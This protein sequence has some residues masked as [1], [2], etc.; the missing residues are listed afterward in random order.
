MSEPQKLHPVT[1][2]SQIFKAIKDNL[3]TIGIALFLAFK[4]GIDFSNWGELIVPGVLLLFTVISIIT[5]VVDALKTTYWI[6]DDKLIMKSGVFTTTVKELYISRIQSIEVTKNVVNQIIGGVV[7]DVKT[8]GEGVKLDSIAESSAQELTHYLETR[9][10]LLLNEDSSEDD[11]IENNAE[12]FNEVY[13]LKAK[14]ILLMSVT[15]GAM[16]TVLA[17]TAGLYTQLDE[18]FDLSGKIA[19]IEKLVAD[20]IIFL[21]G[22]VVAVLLLSYIIGILITAL[23]YHHYQLTYDGERLKIT[24][25]LFE[26]KEKIIIVDQIQA[27]TEEKSFLRQ[28]IGFTSFKA[29]ITSDAE[30]LEELL[31]TVEVLPFIKRQEGID[32]MRQLVPEY[33]YDDVDRIIPR[34]S[35]RRYFQVSWLLIIILTSIVQYYLFDKAWI[36]GLVLLGITGLSAWMRYK[37]SGYRI[38][39]DQITIRSVGLL[40]SRTAMIKEDKMI[41]VK[42]QDNFFMKRVRLA[43]VEVKNSAGSIH[44]SSELKMTDISDAERIYAWFMHK[45]DKAYEIY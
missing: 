21:V 23:K 11:T 43:N 30:E 27:V 7:L 38:T 42:I 5:A 26:R 31:G 24:H 35:L 18:V 9:K 20:S 41:A 22:T 19:P 12:Q 3:F 34:R 2:L 8:P 6:E 15:S 44:A 25:G 1:Y 17:V 4:D 40:T 39:D 14:D 33:H 32:V 45:E 36:I 28:L 10:K 37:F 29:T 13:S 16:G